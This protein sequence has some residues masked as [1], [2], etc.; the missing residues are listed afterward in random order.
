[1]VGQFASLS[2]AGLGGGGVFGWSP[3]PGEGLCTAMRV[4]ALVAAGLASRCM[5]AASLVLL[6]ELAGG[7]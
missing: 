6:R 1:M 4:G 7:V 2:V 5:S 3:G